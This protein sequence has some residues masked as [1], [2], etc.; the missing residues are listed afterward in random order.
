MLSDIMWFSLW[1]AGVC[2]LAALFSC[3]KLGWEWLCSTRSQRQ[4][5]R[6]PIRIERANK[7]V[8]LL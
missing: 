1:L 2:T 7:R 4:Q 3:V 5:F 8:S 6:Y